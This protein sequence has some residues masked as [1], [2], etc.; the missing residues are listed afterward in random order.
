MTIAD[1]IN[2]TVA[3][4]ILT[5]VITFSPRMGA[6]IAWVVVPIVTALLVVTLAVR[7]GIALTRRKGSEMD[8]HLRKDLECALAHIE[9]VLKR[10]DVPEPVQTE[11]RS[12]AGDIQEA[13]R[14]HE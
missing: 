7:I 2:I 13:Q 10:A 8:E 4:L 11:L 9:N 1:R 12:A 6:G 5:V 14:R 3:V